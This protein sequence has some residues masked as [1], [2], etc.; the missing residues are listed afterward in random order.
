[1]N[2][3]Q[4]KFG[5][6]LTLALLLAGCSTPSAIPPTAAIVQSAETPQMRTRDELAAAFDNRKWDLKS[7]YRDA[8]NENP[9]LSSGR[10]VITIVIEPNGRVSEANIRSE[11]FSGLPIIETLREAIFLWHFSAGN[12]FR[13]QVEQGVEFP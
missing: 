10:V 2:I 12:Y 8:K 11:E 6:S 7:V 9:E 5:V 13:I 1:M 3:D 4:C